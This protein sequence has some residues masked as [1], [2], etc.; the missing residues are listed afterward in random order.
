M[1]E[2]VWDDYT[3]LDKFFLLNKISQL[4]QHVLE[5]VSFSNTPFQSVTTGKIMNMESTQCAS[6]NFYRSGAWLD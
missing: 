6:E 5:N 2:T 1:Y 3:F 4:F